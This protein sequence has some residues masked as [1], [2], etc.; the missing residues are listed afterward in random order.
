M[1]RADRARAARERAAG[2]RPSCTCGAQV[3][4]NRDWFSIRNFTDQPNR[5]AIY[6]FQEIGYWGVSA[7]EFVQ[8]LNQLNVDFLDVHINSP[9]GE[10]DDGVAIFN[11]LRQHRARVTVYIDGLA[12]SAASFIAMAGD[13]VLISQFAQVMIHEAHGLEFGDA[14]DMRAMADLLDRY[15]DNIAAIYA[16]RSGGPTAQWRELMRVETWFTGAEA[17]DA[18]LA[19][20][21]YDL[22]SADESDEDERMAVARWDFSVFGF[23][24][25]GRAAA[26][27]PLL[28]TNQ[29][30]A[31]EPR[32]DDA[33]QDAAVEDVD[34]TAPGTPGADG[35]P[36]APQDSGAQTEPVAELNVET[37][38]DPAS[39]ATDPV[40]RRPADEA[41]APDE[42]APEPKDARPESAEPDDQPDIVDTPT[43]DPSGD[44]S[45]DAPDSEPALDDAGTWAQLTAGLTAASSDPDDL[46]ADF[47]RALK[48]AEA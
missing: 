36:P 19:D 38:V 22:L 41:A 8:Q 4:E 37:E 16:S 32:A 2:H 30:A 28:P 7:S 39:T 17:V 14:A 11:A 6:L 40:E 24:H 44:V 20:D 9:G 18:G 21:T 47:T 45:A 3:P 25:G 48:G 46:F 27:A 5:A 10:V 42:A 29:V 1:L 34:T 15:S 35:N 23:R 12:A 13:E 31:V 43:S 33:G 26:P